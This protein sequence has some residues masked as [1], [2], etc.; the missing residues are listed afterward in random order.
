MA[1]SSE[2]SMLTISCCTGS[3]GACV[4]AVSFENIPM[5]EPADWMGVKATQPLPKW[6]TFSPFQSVY[7]SS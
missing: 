2:Q 7:S 6:T 4:V 5:N 3:T 1:P